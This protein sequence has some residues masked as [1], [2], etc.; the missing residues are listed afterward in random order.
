MERR[1]LGMN[2]TN[3]YA[4]NLHFKWHAL[5][6]IYMSLF[7][8]SINEQLNGGADGEGCTSPR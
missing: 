6:F 7:Q 5:V 1:I 8:V 4:K 3:S 2:V